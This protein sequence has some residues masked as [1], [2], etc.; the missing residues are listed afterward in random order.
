MKEVP[1]YLTEIKVSDITGI[2]KSCL[3]Q[4]RW[5]GKGI[6]YVKIGRTVRYQESE[7]LAYLDKLKVQTKPL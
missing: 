5:L 6:P 4:H 7:V 1:K 3:Q 2:S